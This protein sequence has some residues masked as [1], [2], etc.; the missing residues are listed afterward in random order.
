MLFDGGSVAESVVL[1][2]SGG[3]LPSAAADESLPLCPNLLREL[4]SLFVNLQCRT[5]TVF[6]QAPSASR[7]GV[8]PRGKTTFRRGRCYDALHGV[9][10]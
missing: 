9:K 6:G 10:D 8:S 1:G 4:V 7:R 3:S 5:S 2:E